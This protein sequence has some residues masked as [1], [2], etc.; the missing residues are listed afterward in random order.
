MPGTTTLE[1]RRRELNSEISRLR[2]EVVKAQK[3]LDDFHQ[4]HP[5]R[6]DWAPRFRQAR[7]NLGVSQTLLARIAGVSP[8]TIRAA[9]RGDRSLTVWTVHRIA[10]ALGVTAGWLV[11]GEEQR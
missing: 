8:S 10:Q 4:A 3:A 9:E 6:H 11:I 7:E 5:R 2:G 1:Q